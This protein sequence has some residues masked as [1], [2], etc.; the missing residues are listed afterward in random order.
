MCHIFRQIQ[1]GC[2]L[3]QKNK[4]KRATKQPKK[5]WRGETMNNNNNKIKHTFDLLT[6][7]FIFDGYYLLFCHLNVFVVKKN[8]IACDWL[9]GAKEW[10]SCK[11]AKFVSIFIGIKDQKKSGSDCCYSQFDTNRSLHAI[12]FVVHLSSHTLFWYCSFIFV[13]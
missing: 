9:G 13:C 11:C 10:D 7:T 6:H 4:E 8:K 2:I 5:K 1:N 3:W 12:F